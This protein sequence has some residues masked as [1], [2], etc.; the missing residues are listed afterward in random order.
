[1]LP[2]NAGEKY[3]DRLIILPEKREALVGMEIQ[4]CCV[5]FVGTSSVSV[6]LL[7]QS[8]KFD[9]Q[10][11]A[12]IHIIIHTSREFSVLVI[13]KIEFIKIIE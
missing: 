8:R 6:S 1:M 3:S 10:N 2:A 13:P 9:N 5:L 12:V 11:V 4:P 7:I